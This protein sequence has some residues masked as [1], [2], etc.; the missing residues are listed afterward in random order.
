MNKKIMSFVLAMVLSVGLG[1]SSLYASTYLGDAASDGYA[2]QNAASGPVHTS[3]LTTGSGSS[4][5][6]I[7]VGS[8]GDLLSGNLTAEFRYFAGI[9]T[10]YEQAGGKFVISDSYTAM[11][12]LLSNAN[13]EWTVEYYAFTQADLASMPNPADYTVDNDNDGEP[14]TITTYKDAE[15]NEISEE[16]YK[17]LSKKDK[18]KYSPETHYLFE[19]GKEEQYVKDMEN[20]LKER[21]WKDSQLR[22]AK[23]NAQGETVK[24]SNGKIEYESL[25]ADFYVQIRKELSNGLNFTASL[26]SGNGISGPTATIAR[27]GQT[28]YTFTSVNSGSAI[29]EGMNASNTSAMKVPSGIRV[30]SECDYYD[31]GPYKGLLK[32]TMTYGMI[33]TGETREGSDGKK[34]EKY[35]WAMSYSY[36]S[37]EARQDKDGATYYVRTDYTA[38]GLRV[39]NTGESQASYDRYINSAVHAVMNDYNAGDP[40]NKPISFGSG[41]G[42]HNLM[43]YSVNKYSNNGTLLSQYNSQ[44]QNTTYFKDGQYATM[45]KN[46]SGTFTTWYHYTANNV[47]VDILSLTGTGADSTAAYETTVCNEWGIQV[48]VMNG[49]Y[50]GDKHDDALRDIQEVKNQ[51]AAGK[52]TGEGSLDPGTTV[53]SIYLTSKDL[54]TAIAD[55]SIDNFKKYFGWTDADVANMVNFN[56]GDGVVA[57]VTLKFSEQFANSTDTNGQGTAVTADGAEIRT[58]TDSTSAGT[59]SWHQTLGDSVSYSGWTFDSTIMIGGA[60]AY[61]KT[62]DV[63]VSGNRTITI[64]SDPA[65]TGTLYP[66]D[67]DI[68]NMSKEDKE[69]M[70][71]EGLNPDNEADRKTYLLRKK[72]VELGAAHYKTDEKTGERTFVV[73]DKENWGNIQE[74]FYFDKDTNKTYAILS[75]SSIYLMDGS[76]DFHSIKGETILVDLGT[77]TKAE[78]Q[79]KKTEIQNAMKGTDGKIMFMG[80][81]GFGSKDGHL[82]L[83]MKSDWSNGYVAGGDKIAEVQKQII[84]VSQKVYNAI[85]DLKDGKISQEEY[86]KRI[87][88]IKAD[89]KKD[90]YAWVVNN[91]EDNINKFLKEFN[92]NGDGQ[93]PWESGTNLEQVWQVLNIVF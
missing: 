86:N 54:R 83:N 74:G 55:G 16:E 48:G 31:A 93:F 85:S 1:V 9:M 18:E 52:F 5:V 70:K 13:D 67:E 65:V 32:G 20:W 2:D 49:N 34:Y 63:I 45:V 69:K 21:G 46:S 22:V 91:A 92:A 29:P 15:G 87:A 4:G 89:A 35:E 39:R 38:N 43:S 73:D 81:A 30:T 79:V 3:T 68:A 82:V 84:E 60:N 27:D 78:G 44:T 47:M 6:W 53:K 7:E 62:Q 90:G 75:V 72:A 58:T 66:S 88:D 8:T 24:D 80:T 41:D 36:S 50:T 17:N 26:Q 14:D 77:E 40:K 25:S 56:Y 61:S 42:Q 11:K 59:H 19:A 33:A 71:K 37:Y 10:G 51:I 12:A 64:E 28:L 57:M 23:T 76:E